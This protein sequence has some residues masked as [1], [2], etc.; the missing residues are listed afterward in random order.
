MKNRILKA[1]S[2]VVKD[3]LIES[4]YG[5]NVIMQTFGILFSVFTFYFLSKIVD[6]RQTPELIKY[7][8]YFPYVIIGIALSNYL[9]VAT[10]GFSQRI[11]ESQ[12]T[13]TLESILICGVKPGEFL[14]FSTIYDF[15]FST[16]R[17]LVYF[18]IAYFFSSNGF[19]LNQIHLSLLILILSIFAFSSMGVL[20]AGFVL[21]FKRGDPVAIIYSALSY[22]FSG[23]YFPISLLPEQFRFFSQFLPMTHAL[24][25]L[26]KSL[27]TQISISDIIPQ[28]LSLLLFSIVLWP[29]SIFIFKMAVKR[30]KYDGSLSHF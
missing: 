21:M 6:L 3:F 16:L 15:L 8:E 10:R 20:S 5:F 26:R 2:F 12:L 18:L 1:L 11:R 13:G 9:S 17:I 30:A 4:S 28:C 22:L 24:E 29:L 7:K 14:V 23:V 27:L 25:G 19:Y